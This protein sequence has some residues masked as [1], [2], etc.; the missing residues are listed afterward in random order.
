MSVDLS[1]AWAEAQA[2]WPG[3]GI[4]R[5]RFEAFVRERMADDEESA[6]S[7]HLAD[8]YLA[9]ALVESD[10]AA[11]ANFDARILDGVPA[12]V[13][14][15]D[16]DET[17]AKDIVDALRIKLLVRDDPDQPPRVARYLGRGPLRSWVQVAAIRAAY[18]RKRRQSP[19]ESDDEKML[20]A[21]FA[22]DP[23][24][25]ALRDESRALLKSALGEAMTE[26]SSRE[27]TVLRLYLIEELS[28]EAIG[29]MYHVHRGT[30]ARWIGA[31]HA[32]LLSSVRRR[33]LREKGLGPAHLESLLRL[34]G[35][36][37]SVSLSILLR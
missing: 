6:A 5:A 2:T 13:A 29:R 33:L 31:A 23:E 24:L 18:D 10:T 15:I 37:L 28:S 22:D 36:Q 11:L 1:L 35:S 21:P 12:A 3:V 30:V 8:L 25:R 20:D 34:A 27:R 32:Q 26:L 19:E 9:C 7:L 14:R 17:F 16:R 4:D